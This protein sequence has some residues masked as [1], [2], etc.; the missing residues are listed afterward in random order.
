MRV[1]FF[2]EGVDIPASRFR[3]QQFLPHFARAGIECSTFHG[4]DSAYNAVHT[5]R[6]AP[7]YKLAF[8]ARRAL[9]TLTETG[10]DLL[11]FQR[12]AFPFSALP[13]QL[14]QLAGARTIFDFDDLLH[15]GADGQR[16]ASR[17]RTFRAAIRGATHVIAG[18]AYL[19]GLARAPGKTTL[20]PTVID[21]DLYQPR[22]QRPG[23]KA[24]TIGWM[25]TSG[26]F[27]SL[28]TVLPSVMQVLNL[29][30]QARLRLVS[31]AAL[32]D[33]G[34]HPQVE[35]I[36]WNRERELSDLQSFDIGLMP[37]EDSEVTRGKC[38]F[39]M[40]Q[41]MAT[42]TP[43]VASAVGANPQIFEGSRAGAL[44]S[45]GE[46]WIAPLLELCDRAALREESGRT[47]R[48]HVESHFSIKAI[49]P[50]YLELFQRVSAV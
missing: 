21:T 39:K 1:A 48:H 44:L 19:A 36:A 33:V 15:V 25:G 37:L 14:R 9:R 20:L 4:Y 2:T 43:V 50:R 17:E 34:G 42:G 26:N 7:V 12:T 5:R 22:E 32:P 30:P 11:F 28:R 3:C 23:S 46:D 35:Q 49:A 47:G 38:G 40:I 41:Y 10:Y 6:I 31:N 27:G 45:I 18:N 16:S 13:E 8:R 24:L 29:R